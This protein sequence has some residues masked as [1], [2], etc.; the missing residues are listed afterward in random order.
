MLGSE[1]DKRD[2][3]NHK[4]GHMQDNRVSSWPCLLAPNFDIT[5]Y[6]LQFHLLNLQYC[7]ILSQKSTMC[8]CLECIVN[9]YLTKW[10]C[11][12]RENRIANTSF[13]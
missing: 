2:K 11:R 6:F 10:R 7:S 4:I 8:L 12:F 1:N 5:S 13:I 9:L 3:K